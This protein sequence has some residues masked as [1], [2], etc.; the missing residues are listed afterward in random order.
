MQD[1]KG[2]AE[3]HFQVVS[4]QVYVTL[5]PVHVNAPRS[6]R[7][8]GRRSKPGT[9]RP[10]VLRPRHRGGARA[11]CQGRIGARRSRRSTGDREE[12]RATGSRGALRSCSRWVRG[13]VQA[14]SLELDDYGAG[15]DD[16]G[17]ADDHAVPTLPSALQ[18]EANSAATGDIPDNQV[19]LVFRNATAGYSM[20]YPEGWAQRGSGKSSRSG[21]R[22]TSS[23]SSSAGT[24]ADDGLRQR[25]PRQA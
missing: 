24:G 13:L 10:Q 21:T 19:F 22:T 6:R 5:F 23:A 14:D 20:K 11:D 18:A 8:D 15:H 7:S 9:L 25:R 4:R 3:D 17:S 2:Q 12:A 16:H 1:D